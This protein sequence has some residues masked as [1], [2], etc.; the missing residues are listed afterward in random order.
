MYFK[1]QKGQDYLQI[2]THRIEVKNDPP[3]VDDV[4]NLFG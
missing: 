3:D 4:T 1:S 2:Q